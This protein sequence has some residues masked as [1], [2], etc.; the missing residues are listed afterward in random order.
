MKE[1]FIELIHAKVEGAA[2]ES[3][4][5]PLI[6]PSVDPVVR[7]PGPPRT[8]PVLDPTDLS[9]TTESEAEKHASKLSITFFRRKYS[10]VLFVGAVFQLIRYLSSSETRCTCCDCMHRLARRAAVDQRHFTNTHRSAVYSTLYKF[11]IFL[12]FSYST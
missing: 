1:V 2:I 5:S 3:S 12:G 4:Q 8:D 10:K 9:D 6:H 7:L 11:E